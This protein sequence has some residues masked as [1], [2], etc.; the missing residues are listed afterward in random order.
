MQAP[1]LPDISTLQLEPLILSKIGMI[2]D[3]EAR[4]YI[5]RSSL[6][7]TFVFLGDA[8]ESCAFFIDEMKLVNGDIVSDSS[9]NI[10]WMKMNVGNIR[11]S[12][13]VSIRT[14]EQ[15]TTDQSTG[16]WRI[17]VHMSSEIKWDDERR[18]FVSE[19]YMYSG[20]IV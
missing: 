16:V 17:D 11:N 6:L 9:E 7:A 4:L 5:L 2:S 10:D 12:K 18:E 1:D 8:D 15:Q 14:Y 3:K 19:M 20:T 13:P